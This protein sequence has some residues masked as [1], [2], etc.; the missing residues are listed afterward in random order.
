MESAE[1]ASEDKSATTTIVKAGTAAAEDLVLGAGVA[2]EEEREVAGRR[3]G[4]LG[5]RGE[6]SRGRGPKEAG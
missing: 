4:D 3:C 2:E 5:L 6:D 1:F